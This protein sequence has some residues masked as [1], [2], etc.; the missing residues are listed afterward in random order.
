MRLNNT[1][2]AELINGTHL[3]TLKFRCMNMDEIRRKAAG[4]LKMK[5]W[6]KRDEKLRFVLRMVDKVSSR[7]T[8]L[9]FRKVS[10]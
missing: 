10:R 4:D 6:K 8:S 7:G 3:S 5:K 2:R 9:I 1:E